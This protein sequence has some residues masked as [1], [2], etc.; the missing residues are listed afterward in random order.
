MANDS[1]Q[2]VTGG[3][4]VTGP[5]GYVLVV[6]NSIAIYNVIELTFIVWGYFKRHSGLYFS[7]FLVATYGILIYSIGFLLKTKAPQ[8]GAK[9]YVTCIAVGWVAMITGQSMVLWS[10]LHLILRDRFKLRLV[11]HMI[12][13][14]AIIMHIPVVILVY[15]ANMPH[16]D[17]WLKPYSAY[18]KIQVTVFFIQELIISILYIIETAKLARIQTTVQH[19]R[20][21]KRL[22]VHLIAVNII[23]IILDI[24]I[25]AFEY[26]DY[27]AFQ[28]SWKPLL[29]PFMQ[30]DAN[31]HAEAVD[32]RVLL[33]D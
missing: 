9:L 24:T 4:V 8:S 31:E 21:P 3:K 28:T 29:R 11:L 6:F 13:T 33:N 23:I 15:G 1:T 19:Q 25:L 18:E 20:T 30:G 32:P 2:A 26:A 14:N 17:P 27:Y 22:I 5:T 12:I 16:P 7:S 10:R